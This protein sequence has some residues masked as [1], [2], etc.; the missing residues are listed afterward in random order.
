[1]D[2]KLE[3]FFKIY[4]DEG[5]CFIAEEDRETAEYLYPGSE[6]RRIRPVKGY[7][8]PLS[9]GLVE[10]FKTPEEASTFYNRTMGGVTSSSLI[11]E[12]YGVRE[13]QEL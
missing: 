13:R 12:P 2:I 7:G 3:K 11:M 10:V 1:M 9:S 4:G 6:I 8:I 5:I